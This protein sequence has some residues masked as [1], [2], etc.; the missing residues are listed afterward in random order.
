MCLDDEERWAPWLTKARQWQIL[1]NRA[2]AGREYYEMKLQAEAEAKAEGALGWEA[3]AALSMSSSPKGTAVAPAKKGASKSSRTSAPS[4]SSFD[5]DFDDDDGDE[6]DEVKTTRRSGKSSS[7]KRRKEDKESK[8]KGLP[9]PGSVFEAITDND[10]LP[11]DYFAA[12]RVGEY[13][14]KQVGAIRAAVDD[15]RQKLDVATALGTAKSIPPSAAR[16]GVTIKGLS[17]ATHAKRL[18]MLLRHSGGTER[19]ADVIGGLATK[20]AAQGGARGER[21]RPLASSSS[22]SLVSAW[23]LDILAVFVALGCIAAA[24]ARLFLLL[25]STILSKFFKAWRGTFSSTR[26]SQAKRAEWWRQASILEVVTVGVKSR[27]GGRGH[28]AIDAC[29]F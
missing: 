3:H 6:M 26:R 13:R 8:N 4:P 12:K 16:A 18:S 28:A 25:V 29:W 22:A 23:G 2:M 17:F 11:V 10:L 9:R 21:H 7:T 24:G 5:D 15:A 20:A 1:N 19:A 27:A 14:L